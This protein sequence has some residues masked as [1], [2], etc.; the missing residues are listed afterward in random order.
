[1]KNKKELEIKFKSG[2]E[3]LQMLQK[4]ID[5]Y[6]PKT[7]V[8]VFLYSNKGA[9]A[10]YNGIQKKDALRYASEQAEGTCWEEIIG[11]SGFICDVPSETGQGKM[12]NIDLCNEQHEGLWINT[13]NL[14]QWYGPYMVAYEI[15]WETDG[16]DTDLPTE[17]QI[18]ADQ[19]SIGDGFESVSNYLSDMTDCLNSY[20]RVGLCL[21]GE[22]MELVINSYED[23]IRFAFEKGNLLSGG[24][25]ISFNKREEKW[26]KYVI[27]YDHVQKFSELSDPDSYVTEEE[28]EVIEHLCDTIIRAEKEHEEDL[29]EI[30]QILT[31]SSKHLARET[32]ELLDDSVDDMEESPM[33]PVYEKQGFGWFIACDPS[34]DAE[35][36]WESIYPK[37]LVRVMKFAKEKG[38]FWLCIDVEGPL[39]KSL[40]IYVE[41]E[42]APSELDRFTSGLAV[43]REGDDE[44]D[45]ILCPFCGYEVARNDDYC[46]MR[47][48][49][50]PECGTKLIY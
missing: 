18:P 14:L 22:I 2:E 42:S 23:N 17:M 3:M 36:P 6:N 20:F 21:R 16:E 33:P 1:M 47:P 8:Y 37:D 35:T 31:I 11:K 43:K 50:C 4:G 10:Y 7:G 45:G 24:H 48:K 12:S 15:E 30:A 46:D 19:I 38:C 27:W 13:S 26:E 49:H 40:P 29:L 32:K 41:N 5:L 9:I 39:V 44:S 25:V 28:I 34:S